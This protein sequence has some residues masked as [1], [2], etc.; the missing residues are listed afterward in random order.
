MLYRFVTDSSAACGSQ[1]LLNTPTDIVEI[2][3]DEALQRWDYPT[4][5]S[6][7]LGR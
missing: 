6:C 4:L 3:S 2:E 5:A 1:N 7:T